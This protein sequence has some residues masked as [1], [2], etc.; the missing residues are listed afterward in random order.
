MIFMAEVPEVKQDL[1]WREKLTYIWCI[2]RFSKRIANWKVMNCENCRCNELERIGK[3]K[4]YTENG[5]YVFEQTYKCT[6]C[7]FIG[8]VTQRWREQLMAKKDLAHIAKVMYD[9]QEYCRYID[10]I[11]DNG[12]CDGCTFITDHVKCKLIKLTKDNK[13]PC[14]NWNITKADIER[15]ERENDD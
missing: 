2:L 1:T 6:R 15:L 9:L 5:E 13:I 7:G 11:N 14:D 10:E 12:Y 3:A 4:H 8:N